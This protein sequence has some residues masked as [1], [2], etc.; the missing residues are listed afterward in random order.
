MSIEVIQVTIHLFNVR[1]RIPF[2]YGIATMTAMPHCFL[3]AVCRIDG[4]ESVGLA[5]D[6]LVPKWFTKDPASNYAD[7]IEE[8]LIVIEQAA[9]W[10][11]TATPQPDVF[12]LWLHIYNRQ[13]AW[14]E[15]RGYPPLLW[16]F[17]V[18]LTERAIIDAFCRAS[19]QTFEAVVRDNSLGIVLS[20]I[21]PELAG[22][23]PADLLP[24]R[25]LRTI[26]VRHT[27]G[28]ADPLTDAEIPAAERLEDGLPQSLQSVLIHYG[29]NYLKIKIGGD[30]PQDLAR[31]KAIAQIVQ[32]AGLNDFQF[33][34]DGNEQYHELAGFRQLWGAICADD[35]LKPFMDHLLFVEQP[36]HRSVALNGE[37]ARAMQTW[38][39]GPPTI[40][41]E[42]DADLTSLRRALSCG[43]V[44]TSHKN[45]KGV[46]KG[47]AN[48]CYL[49]FLA[50]RDPDQVL[51][52]S[53]EDLTNIGPVALLQDLALMATL[54]IEHVERNG[55]HYFQGLSMLPPDV[56]QQ[57]LQAHG[58]LYEQK[59]DYPTPAIVDGKMAIGSVVD[60]PFGY[61][62][63]LDPTQ[64]TPRSA[65]SFASMK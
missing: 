16:N 53:G 36:L 34:L 23:T 42:S 27:I 22:K 5:A 12:Q 25:A 4:Q 57:V 61:G 47:L 13:K 6:S 15:G 59:H 33:T 26:A 8:M 46:I 11:Q 40:I 21:H 14:A 28:L 7:D 39:D 56:Q 51:V 17:G 24:E 60:A 55:H 10:A 41:D 18:S 32:E 30:V 54:G 9:H 1:T 3:R 49:N 31:L 65:W 19:G 58:D 38:D 63:D 45:C 43:Y 2:K 20:E 64:F 37:T 29:V 62:F 35:A 48:A 52:L 50:G 44:G